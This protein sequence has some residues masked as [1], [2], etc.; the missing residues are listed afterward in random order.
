MSKDQVAGTLIL[1]FSLV[2][3]GL[4][5]YMIYIPDLR[6]WAT[7]IVTTVAAIGVLGVMAWIGWTMATTPS[8]T[9]FEDIPNETSEK[10]S[11]DTNENP[12]KSEE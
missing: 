9:P 11:T 12:K 6:I 5:G 4:Y 8:P 10:A 7:V 1:L 3:L 2:L